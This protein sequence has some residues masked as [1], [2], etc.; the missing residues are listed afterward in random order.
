M[1]KRTVRQHGKLMG[2]FGKKAACCLL[3]LCIVMT[4]ANG[5]ALEAMAEDSS[6]GIAAVE[7]DGAETE[8]V[9]AESANDEAAA[10]SDGEPGEAVVSEDD[11][12]HDGLAQDSAAESPAVDLVTLTVNYR[13]QGAENLIAEP[14]IAQQVA[15][16][17]YEVES[18]DIEGFALVDEAQGVLSGTMDQDESID[19][20]YTYAK[21]E[22]PYSVVYQ[23]YDPATGRT[24]VLDTVVGYAPEGET[25]AIEYRDYAGYDKDETNDMFL[26]VTADGKASKTLNYTLKKDPCVIFRTQGS[27]VEPI[28]SKMGSDISSQVLSIPVPSRD[29]Y[30]FVGWQYE[31][32][33][34][35]N[36]SALAAVLQEMPALPVFVDAVW[37]PAEVTY[38]VLTWFENADDDGYTLQSNIEIR[39]GL[40]GSSATASDADIANGENDEHVDGNLYFGFDYSHCDDD[41]VES[42]GTAVLN[43][44]Y[45]REI[46]KINLYEPDGKTIWKTYEGKYF[47]LVP[48]DFPT[49]E[50][51]K[52]HYD[53]VRPASEPN[54]F[55]SMSKTP[56]GTDSP[57]LE[58]FENS[59]V[60]GSGYGEE[61]AYPHY[62]SDAYRF[63]ARYYCETLD[64]EGDQYL[65]QTGKHY[66][67]DYT[68]YAYYYKPTA[69][70]LFLYPVYGF[71]WDEYWRTSRSESTLDQASL[72]DTVV[73]NHDT[74]MG[75]FYGTYQ[76][77]DMY[78]KRVRSMLRYVSNGEVVKSVED[79]P[80]GQS[81]DLGLVPEN[82]EEHMRFA[83]WYSDPKLMN[84]TEPLSEYEMIANDL[85]LY[86]KW[87]PVEYAVIFDSQGGSSVPSQNVAYNSSATEPEA[88][89]RDG[90]T[91]VGW[92]TEPEGGD[93]WV[94]DRKVEEDIT[95]YAH[96][97]KSA[98]ASF[99]VKHQIEGQAEPFYVEVGKSTIGDSVFAS[100]LDPT[101]ERYPDNVYLL[102]QEASRTI[103]VEQGSA[104]E[105]TF[106]YAEVGVK[107]YKVS[108]VDAARAKA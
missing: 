79:V 92:Y 97:R 105:V 34:Y 44:Y 43:L 51:M 88:P 52:S 80:Y 56:G 70:G 90:Y 11:S 58:R 13:L 39:E 69:P 82:G 101:D 48:D 32:R 107:D 89:V 93:R 98:T 37:E 102:P 68:S 108:Y 29:G 83:G 65:L 99:I 50:E 81:L 96:W 27:Y 71:T 6:D 67:L 12:G 47:S 61:N 73:I 42:D 85:S 28:V 84:V 1:F 23:G 31:G 94:F 3:A 63:E 26:T 15:G 103:T 46:W 64:S 55:V 19:V 22:F 62:S 4:Y 18:P 78:L 76:F 53:A 36:A 20:Y 75:L 9:V 30:A 38:T 95:L 77:S 16:S 106:L 7:E 35:E 74:G 45:D 24:A 25:V 57:L 40:V 33:V 5:S 14:Y 2:E 86:A 54:G 8:G 104:N 10:V 49:Y 41:V 17:S 100:A 59:M 66:D 91:F 60:Y 87:G 72:K 21:E